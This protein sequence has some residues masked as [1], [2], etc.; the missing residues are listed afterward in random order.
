M[1]QEGPMEQF[2]YNAFTGANVPD[3][4]FFLYNT[5]EISSGK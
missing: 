3:L 2:H 5:R 4:T 1:K